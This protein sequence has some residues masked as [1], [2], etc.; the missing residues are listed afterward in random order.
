LNATSR[1]QVALAVTL[2]LVVM[3]LAAGPARAQAPSPGPA[4]VGDFAGRLTLADGRSLF[5]ECHGVG[6]PTV[7]FEAGLRARGDAWD[8]SRDGSSDDGVFPRVSA[9]TRACTYDRPGTV[10]GSAV[11]SRSDPV[12]M[13]RSTGEIVTDLHDLLL[14]AGVPGPYVLVGASTGGL[15]ARQYTGRYPGEVA[16]IV[17]VDA[18][19]EAMEGRMKPGQFARYNL[20]YLQSRSPQLAGYGDLETIDFYRSFAEMRRK[21]RPPRPIPEVV[22]SNDWGFGQASGVTPG[23]A[24]LVNRVWKRSQTYLASLEPGIR[25]LTAFGS[26]HQIAINRPGLVARMVGRVVARARAR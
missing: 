8:Y 1:A 23:F 11:E 14:G 22:I 2:L 18:L 17:L 7:V 9:F 3:S 26:G 21:R 19:S 6:S 12:P 10:L 24:H 20:Y 5:L 4:T 15:I 25:Q 16:G 13:P